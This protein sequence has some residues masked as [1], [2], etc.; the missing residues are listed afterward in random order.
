MQGRASGCSS[1]PDAGRGRVDRVR[2]RRRL[3]PDLVGLLSGA[4]GEPPTDAAPNVRGA[5]HRASAKLL[6]DDGGQTVTLSDSYDNSFTLGLRRPRS[7]SAPPPASPSAAR[8]C[9]SATARSRCRDGNVPD[10]RLAAHVPSRWHRHGDP[11][12]SRGDARA[13]I[14]SCSAPTR[15]SSPGCP[16]TIGSL[17]I[18]VRAGRVAAAGDAQHGQRR[19][20]AHRP[21]ASG[22]ARPPPAPFRDGDRDHLDPDEG[23]R[24]MSMSAA[25]TR[26]RCRSTEP[27]R[28]RRVAE[29][30]GPRRPD[31]APAAPDQPRRASL[32]AAVRVRTAPAWCS[33]RRS[34]GLAGTVQI[35]IQNAINQWLS[36]QVTLENGDRR[37]SAPTRP[38]ASP[39]RASSIPAS[40]SIDDLLHRRRLA[41]AR[42]E[43][44]L[45]V[46]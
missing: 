11:V 21:T 38:L 40:C 44:E 23:A 19:R 18:S 28:R 6:F 5:R 4:A 25:T 9:R 32:P 7:R 29:L 43:L 26:S 1:L 46:K 42:A 10:R 16:F 3:L 41:R 2:G 35:H 36:D 24:P 33:L 17:P 22:C 13:E 39:H 14:R 30:P 20:A 15:S 37:L 45:I 27:P 31:A 12:R 8:R 34:T